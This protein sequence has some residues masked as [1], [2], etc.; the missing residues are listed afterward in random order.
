MKHTKK[1]WFINFLLTLIAF[2][3]GTIIA[4]A[5]TL[6][7]G[8]VIGD[9]AGI[10]A[11]QEGAY[12][13]DLVNIYPGERYTKEITIRSLDVEEP[14]ELGLLVDPLTSEGI[15]DLN[16][17]ITLTLTL[18]G[19]EIYQGPIL[20]NGE[21]DWTLQPLDLG[22]C[23]FGTD[24]ILIAEFNISPELTNEDYLQASKMTYQWTFVAIRNGVEPPPESS[25]EDPEPSTDSSSTSTI[26]S[27]SSSIATGKP[28]PNT[29][30]DRRAAIYKMI[31]GCLLVIIVWLLWKRKEEG[32]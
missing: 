12:F 1:Q 17:V 2:C 14:F 20:G 23:S 8:M 6:P 30:E 9:D 18:D 10:Y 24:K 28:L 11:T 22:T 19:E 7:S 25:S 21:F 27:T 5:E 32:R 26:P 13:I 16:K 3:S 4:H 15:I 29:G 31:I